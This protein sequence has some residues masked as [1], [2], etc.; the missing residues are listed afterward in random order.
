MISAG[1]NL[2]IQKLSFYRI[3]QLSCLLSPVHASQTSYV[4]NAN[5][6]NQGLHSSTVVNWFRERTISS[7]YVHSV[8]F[9]FVS[10]IRT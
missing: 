8:Q 5:N 2:K 6:C 10:S 3:E 7:Y 4:K 9:P 1:F